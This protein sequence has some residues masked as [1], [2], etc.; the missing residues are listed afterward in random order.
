M[1]PGALWDRDLAPVNT[2]IVRKTKM[3]FEVADR[4]GFEIHGDSAIFKFFHIDFQSAFYLAIK[5]RTTN[6]KHLLLFV[7]LQG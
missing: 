5:L 7:V 6:L 2:T 3:Y 1:F 4:A